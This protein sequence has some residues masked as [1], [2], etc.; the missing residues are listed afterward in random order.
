MA[1]LSQSQQPWLP[2]AAASWSAGSCRQTAAASTACRYCRERRGPPAAHAHSARCAPH[3]G[4]WGGGW[5]GGGAAARAQRV[6]DARAYD[7]GGASAVCAAKGEWGAR[8]AAVALR[9][10][11]SSESCLRLGMLCLMILT[12]L[13]RSLDV[14]RLMPPESV[15]FSLKLISRVSTTCGRPRFFPVG[16]VGAGGVGI[17]ILGNGSGVAPSDLSASACASSFECCSSSCAFSSCSCAFSSCSCA[18]SSCAA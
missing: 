14:S 1:P 3:V 8:A 4:D 12:T 5:L 10:S 16:A 7:E 18:F 13:E 11:I 15:C 17:T 2:F 6:A 9:T